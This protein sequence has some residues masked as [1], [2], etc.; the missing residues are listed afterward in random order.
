MTKQLLTGMLNHKAKQAVELNLYSQASSKIKIESDILKRCVAKI[1]SKSMSADVFDEVQ[2]R[3][4]H[5]FEFI[6]I[7]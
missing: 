2:A 1:K 6:V 5:Q 3:V 7:F 4:G